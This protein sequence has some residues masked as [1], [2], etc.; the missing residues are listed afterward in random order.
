MC[1]LKKDLYGLKQAPRTWYGRIDSFLMI[2]GFTK[3]K[4]DPNMYYKVVDGDQVIFLLY[5]DNLFLTD[6]EKLI[7][8]SKRKFPVELDMKDLGTM[9]YF[10]SLEVW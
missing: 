9:N 6:D 1:R 4:V 3:S 5:M 2:L 10:L 7:V 8:D